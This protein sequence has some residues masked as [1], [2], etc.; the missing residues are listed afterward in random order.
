[1]ICSRRDEIRE[2]FLRKRSRPGVVGVGWCILK[3]ICIGRSRCR[4]KSK[5]A[6]L[7][8]P[9]QSQHGDN[10]TRPPLLLHQ[11]RTITERLVEVTGLTSGSTLK[12][13]RNAAFIN[14]MEK[15]N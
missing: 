1:M 14:Y 15:D 7:F 12:V 11:A 4:P 8:L 10:R 13:S 2:C 6:S 3:R 9:T 5:R